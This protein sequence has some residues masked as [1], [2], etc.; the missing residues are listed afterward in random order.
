MEVRFRL[1]GVKELATRLDALGARLGRNTLRRVGRKALVPVRD[2]ARRFA[3]KD[4]GDLA[5]SIIISSTLNRYQ[6]GQARRTK[7]R[8]AVS[9]Y[10]GPTSPIGI[11]QEFG[12]AHHPATPFMRRAWDQHGREVLEIVIRELRPEIERTERRAGVSLTEGR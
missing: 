1:E 7:E 3:P 4:D 8:A 10:V 6:F 12:T 9:M 5:R 11:L 2:A